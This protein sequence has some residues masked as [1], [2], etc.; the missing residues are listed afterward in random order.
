MDTLP[1]LKYS[2]I[3]FYLYFTY[4]EVPQVVGSQYI[5]LLFLQPFCYLDPVFEICDPSVSLLP[6]YIFYIKQD[7]LNLHC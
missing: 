5:Y 2:G 6:A 3:I 7:I 1:N 4:F